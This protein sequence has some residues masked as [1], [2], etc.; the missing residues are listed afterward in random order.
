MVNRTKLLLSIVIGFA[1]ITI[2]TWIAFEIYYG[3]DRLITA[4][5]KDDLHRVE[6]IL[7]HGSFENKFILNKALWQ[8]CTGDNS[9]IVQ[10]LLDAGADV[11]FGGWSYKQTSESAETEVGIGLYPLEVAASYRR[12][13]VVRLLIQ[14]GAFVLKP[15]WEG[16]RT[17]PLHCALSGPIW[18]Q[19]QYFSPDPNISPVLAAKYSQADAGAVALVIIENGGANALTDLFDKTPMEYAVANKGMRNVLKALMDR[20]FR[21]GVRDMEEAR[22]CG[23]SEALELFMKHSSD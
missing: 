16:K 1:V 12:I 2:T 5:R 14:R 6:R 15:N 13:N 7:A 4:V 9:E 19:Y 8:A 17:T 11:N 18:D 20:G 3:E 23:N 22:Q 10:R 21:P